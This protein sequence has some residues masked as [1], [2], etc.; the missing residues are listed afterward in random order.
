YYK[1][2]GER[3]FCPAAA[4]KN[5]DPNQPFGVWGTTSTAWHCRVHPDG[6]AGSYGMNAWCLDGMGFGYRPRVKGRSSWKTVNRNG[7]YNVPVFFDCM[8]DWVMPLET[9]AP[10][11]YEDA[12]SD[13]VSFIAEACMNRHDGGTNMLF[14]DWSVRHVGVKELWTLKWYP[15]YN[16]AGPWT[17]TGGAKPQDWPEWMRKF[18][19]Y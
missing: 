7:A 2:F 11:L 14:M 4:N 13:Y 10:P 1:S 5:P 16:T 18:K 8:V 3:F 6:P 12:F 17:K 19:D 15:E 9:D